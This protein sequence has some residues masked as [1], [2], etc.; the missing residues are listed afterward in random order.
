MPICVCKSQNRKCACKSQNTHTPSSSWRIR[1]MRVAMVC[2][3]YI[4]CLADYMEE[5]TSKPSLKQLK[6]NSKVFWDLHTFLARL[7]HECIIFSIF[8]FILKTYSAL[9]Y[10]CIFKQQIFPFEEKKSWKMY[11]CSNSDVSFV[12]RGCGG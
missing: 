5:S 2:Y 8:I 6:Q 12:F 11:F 3:D 9:P 7:T 10:Q 4:W 1:Q